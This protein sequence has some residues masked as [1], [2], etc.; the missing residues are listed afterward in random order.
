MPQTLKEI[1][2]EN[3]LLFAGVVIPYFLAAGLMI[4]TEK[5]MISSPDEYARRFYRAVAG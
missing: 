4:G 2:S 3:K 5:G 1:L